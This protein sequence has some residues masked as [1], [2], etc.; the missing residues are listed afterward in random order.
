MPSHTLKTE[1]LCAFYGKNQILKDINLVVESG[2]CL[3]LSGPNGS[4]KSTLLSLLTGT[5][6]KTLSYTGKILLDNAPVH[7]MKTKD[8]AKKIAFMS[9]SESVPWNFS[10]FDVILSGRFAHTNFTGIYSQQDKQIAL[11]A[12]EEVKATHLL[13][14][15]IHTLSGGEFQRVRI[16]RTFAQQPKMLVLD[17]PMASLDFDIS[18]SLFKLT[19]KLAKDKG[20]GVLVSIHDINLASVFAD[21]MALLSP[22]SR[23]LKNQLHSGTPGQILTPETLNSVYGNEFGV[24]SHPIYKTPTIYN[25]AE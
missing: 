20:I 14:R 8:L 15:K 10:C 22:C 25:L 1:A 12:A 17:E 13:Q 18:F 24:F 16:A 9:Q 11:A 7:S 6:P 4:G 23:N 2:V 19:K 21:K 5:N 3:C